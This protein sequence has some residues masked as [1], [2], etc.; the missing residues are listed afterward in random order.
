[1]KNAIFA[2]AL[3][4]SLIFI[5]G[6]TIVSGN[7]IVTGIT[8]SPIGHNEVRIYRVPPPE[9][10]EIAMISASAGH[11]FRSNEELINSAIERLKKEAAKVGAN[12]VLLAGIN[13]RDSAQISTSYVNANANVNGNFATASGNAITVD[14]G[15][16]YTRIRGLAIYVPEKP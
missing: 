7:A 4:S 9:Y 10:E 3:L 5:A 13:E 16:T 6:C 11:D 12:G 8:K 15:D 1:M 14:R 2:L